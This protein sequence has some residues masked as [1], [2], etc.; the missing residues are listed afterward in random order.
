LSEAR[1][2]FAGLGQMLYLPTLSAADSATRLAQAPK[3]SFIRVLDDGAEAT[4]GTGFESF[5]T[6]SGEFGL[7]FE[8]FIQL[9]QLERN[10][11]KER[12]VGNWRFARGVGDTSDLLSSA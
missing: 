1:L 4:L 3:Q 9:D 11:R 6:C 8:S 7:L 12:R 10:T 5:E 2:T